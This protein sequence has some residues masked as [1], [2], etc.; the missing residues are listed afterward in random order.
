VGDKVRI[1]KGNFL[2]H[3]GVLATLPVNQ[4]TMLLLSLLG[5]E[6]RVEMDS[7]DIEAISE[8]PPHVASG[9]QQ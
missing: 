7:R 4:R 2:N 6:V 5:R 9:S 8:Q 3:I 1:T